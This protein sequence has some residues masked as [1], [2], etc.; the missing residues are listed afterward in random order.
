M[1]T[2]ITEQQ[3]KDRILSMAREIDKHYS[4]VEKPVVVLGV[5]TGAIFFMAD[6]V[7]KMK[8]ETTLDFIR[9]ST[10][11][12]K[13]TTHQTPV[14]VHGQNVCLEGADV[15]LVDDILDTGTTIEFIK[16]QL[17][18]FNLNS[19]AIATLLRKPKSS[20]TVEESEVNFVGFDIPDKFV[21][22]CG[23]DYDN[24]FRSTS[25][26]VELEK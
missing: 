10:Y 21:I 5:L 13:S 26:I 22:G 3:I 14:M 17:G 4:D 12:G 9:V 24:K 18:G 20:R 16:Q 2:L 7:R 11:P 25:D 19:L 1:K 23:L 15:L 8:T 6:L